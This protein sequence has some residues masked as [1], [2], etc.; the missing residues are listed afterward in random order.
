M[1]AEREKSSAVVGIPGIF[2]GSVT[3]RKCVIG[4]LDGSPC[5]MAMVPYTCNL[6]K[7]LPRPRP[8][9]RMQPSSY[10]QHIPHWTVIS[11]IDMRAA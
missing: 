4:Y 5:S 9:L 10:A 2:N 1:I 6:S 8:Q 3:W 7:H 11:R